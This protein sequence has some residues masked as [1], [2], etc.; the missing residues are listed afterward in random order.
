[1][2]L[3]TVTDKIEPLC[4][5]EFQEEILL[6][7]LISDYPDLI[8]IDED[9]K[10]FVVRRQQPIIDSEQG[11][12][13]Y[14]LDVLFVDENAVPVL[15]EVK[16]HTDTRIRREVV[17]QM[18]DYAMGMKLL[19]FDDLRKS[20][21]LS[22]ANNAEI[23]AKYDTDEFWDKVKNN[24][25]LE[26]MN[27]VFVADRIPSS[28]V[29]FIEFMNS[30]LQDICVYG[31]ELKEYKTGS[32]KVI[33]KNLIKWDNNS[34]GKS[35]K[36]IKGIDWNYDRI[37]GFVSENHN[38][39]LPTY[40]KLVEY[41]LENYR[42]KYGKGSLCASVNVWTNDNHRLFQVDA[43]KESLNISFHSWYFSEY[44]EMELGSGENLEKFFKDES[45]RTIAGSDE[46]NSISSTKMFL[47]IP[48]EL[49]KNDSIFD[50]FIQK[51]KD[52]I[53]LR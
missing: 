25:E 37:M 47:T 33:E 5:N 31:V 21:R 28:L 1:M 34:A 7:N 39:M 8:S 4:L 9:T 44:S 27:L 30:H 38:G 45:F 17:A 18:L 24:L 16:R 40:R 12:H 43:T 13:E 48:L 6:E 51:I 11:E 2:K 19:N 3:F 50:W 46:I 10:H 42:C 14:Y 35:S 29:T 26:R 32:S 22:N 49:L 20:F 41:L 23:L 53:K 36:Q 15:A 52:I